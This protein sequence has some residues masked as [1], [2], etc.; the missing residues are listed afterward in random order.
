MIERKKITYVSF[1]VETTGTLPSEHSMVAF[2]AVALEEKGWREIS[3]LSIN[4]GEERNKR[5]EVSTREWWNEPEQ[6]DAL[7]EW[8]RDPANPGTAMHQ[9][10]GWLEILEGDVP[11]N[12]VILAAYPITF[13][14]AFLNDYMLRYCRDRWKAFMK[15]NGYSGLDIHTVAALR[16][17][18]PLPQARRKYWPAE[19]RFDAPMDHRALDDA[20]SQGQ[21]LKAMMTHKKP[22][23]VEVLPVL[24]TWCLQCMS[25]GTAEAAIKG[26]LTGC[27][28]RAPTPLEPHNLVRIEVCTHTPQAVTITCPHGRFTLKDVTEVKW[29]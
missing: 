26:F 8:Q 12:L 28:M 4:I 3:S 20:R 17:G 2:G 6:A 5:W 23:E 13:D 15:R 19:W 21:S 11:D 9:I 16:M 18:V 24:E 29:R 7:K 27:S 25:A 14:W 10:L 22:S 1:D